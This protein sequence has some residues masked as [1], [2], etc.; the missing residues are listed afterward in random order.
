M[1]SHAVETSSTLRTMRVGFLKD[2]TI[3][4]RFPF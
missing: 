2:D 4:I 1:R 3:L